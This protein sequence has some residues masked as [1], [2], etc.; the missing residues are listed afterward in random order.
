MGKPELAGDPRFATLALRK[1]HED[2]LEDI[3]TAWTRPRTPDE[4]TR[5]L[6]AAGVP[7]FT[8]NTY[9]DVFEDA[10]LN[11]RGFFVDIDH[12]TFGVRTHPGVPWRMRNAPA[13]ITSPSPLLGQHTEEVLQELG[14]SDS[15]IEDLRQAGALT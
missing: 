12:P 8:C 2:E 7:A 10:N 1:R 14:Y 13:D 5:M 11:Q 15:A 3:I 9:K 6:Q 4:V